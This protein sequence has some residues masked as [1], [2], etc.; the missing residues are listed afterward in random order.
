[1]DCR[2]FVFYS[3]EREMEPQMSPIIDVTRETL[4]ERR[5]EVLRRLRMDAEEFAS[6][7]H[8][9]TLTADESEA[10]EELEAIDFL[11][12]SAQ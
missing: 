11:L 6:A 5:A 3:D 1:M 2:W 7:R 12:G 4:E 9:R 8:A 10:A